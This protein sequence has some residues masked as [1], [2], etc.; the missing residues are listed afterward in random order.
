MLK[1]VGCALAAGAAIAFNP[2]FAGEEPYALRSY[3]NIGGQYI[4]VD[5]NS[6]Q[7]DD[8]LGAFISVGKPFSR[9][10][11]MEF[12]AFLSSFDSDSS[13]AN[14]D[15]DEYGGEIAALLTYPMSRGWVPYL[16]AGVGMTNSDGSSVGDSYDGTYYTGAGFFKYFNVDEDTELGVRF[17][18]RYRVIDV[19]D[20]VGGGSVA[21]FNNDFD[22]AVLRLA[23]VVPF[24]EPLVYA[25]KAEPVA[26]PV[27]EE[28]PADSDGDGVIDAKD[29]CPDT[30]AGTEVDG[31]GC[32]LTKQIG[33]DDAPVAQ[34]GPIYF[35]YNRNDLTAEAR[36]KLDSAAAT[37][38]KLKAENP[39]LTVQV[40]GHTDDRGTDN[41]NIGLGERR[42][43]AVK[44]YLVRKGVEADR[45][46]V[47]SFGESRPSGDNATAAGRALNRRAE[48]EA[49]K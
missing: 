7:S 14:N 33:G 46:E 43:N 10:F 39:K 24:G 28:G 17:D 8:G 20:S 32:P 1:K 22:E 16:T 31:K 38:G 5:D 19:N 34:F 25:K 13:P 48:V 45:I 12:T 18:V 37:I 47:T 9:Y 26:A 15:W 2:A 40:S 44:A 30:P 36:A 42:A 35:G 4:F 29:M 6:R 11:G 3:V 23:L 49:Y 21:P 27:V 41:Y